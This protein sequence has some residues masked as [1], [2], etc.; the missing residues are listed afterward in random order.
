MLI[1]VHPQWDATMRWENFPPSFSPIDIENF[2]PFQILD[3]H[4]K[5]SSD[6]T[7]YTL[8]EYQTLAAYNTE[9]NNL[10]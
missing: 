10:A 2:L 3:P 1:P 6:I 8:M 9:N 7:A 5:Q 4:I